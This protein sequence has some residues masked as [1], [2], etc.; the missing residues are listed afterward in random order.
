[1]LQGKVA[2]APQRTQA[3]NLQEG[4]RI[5]ERRLRGGSLGSLGSNG[6]YCYAKLSRSLD[7][8]VWDQIEEGDKWYRLAQSSV[9]PCMSQHRLFLPLS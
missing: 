9:A 3:L 7:D 1:M 2:K 6:A 4:L 8:Q 5:Q